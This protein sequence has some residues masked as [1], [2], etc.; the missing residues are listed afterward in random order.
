ME[1]GLKFDL[2]DN[3]L[4]SFNQMEE[5]TTGAIGQEGRENV[6]EKTE[7]LEAREGISDNSI[8]QDSI[9]SNDNPEGATVSEGKDV[10]IWKARG[11]SSSSISSAKLTM[12]KFDVGDESYQNTEKISLSSVVTHVSKLQ[13]GKRRG[14]PPKKG[15]RKTLKGFSFKNGK[16]KKFVT[17][18]IPRNIDSVSSKVLESCLLMGLGLEMCNVEA[19]S[20]IKDRLKQ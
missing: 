10:V 5:I 16:P 14:R 20:H 15:G 9:R 2:S 3:K 13:L 11:Q 12:D 17:S 1:Q 19:L 4:D 18:S 8:V 6:I 7:R